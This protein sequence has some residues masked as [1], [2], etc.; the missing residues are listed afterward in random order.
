MRTAALLV[1]A[2]LTGCAA[3]APCPVCKPEI[4]ADLLVVC[5]QGRL[6]ALSD[7]AQEVMPISVRC[8]PGRAERP[9]HT[10]E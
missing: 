7:A 8:G 3:P 6:Y 9:V 10:K 4:P 1:L 2:V 5:F